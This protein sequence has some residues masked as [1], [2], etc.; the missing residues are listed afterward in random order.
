[1]VNVFGNMVKKLKDERFIKNVS[2]SM[3]PKPEIN[4]EFMESYNQYQQRAAERKK[5][6]KELQLT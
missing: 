6:D 1:M 3:P 2:E 5:K 4:P